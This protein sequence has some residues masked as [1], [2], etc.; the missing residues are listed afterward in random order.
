MA[1]S[2]HV[3]GNMV[4]LQVEYLAIFQGLSEI[5]FPIQLRSSEVRYGIV[6]G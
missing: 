3:C 4:Y 1:H 5:D 6:T 2:L